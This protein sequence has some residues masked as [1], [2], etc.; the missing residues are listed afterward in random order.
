MFSKKM[1]LLN[2]SVPTNSKNGK[3]TVGE[4]NEQGAGA[5]LAFGS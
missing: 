4:R 2:W 5:A 1:L 3:R